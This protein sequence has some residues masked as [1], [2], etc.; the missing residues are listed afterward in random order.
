MAVVLDS[1]AMLAELFKEPGAEFVMAHA[2]EPIASAVNTAEVHAKL[3]EPSGRS[4]AINQDA[5]QIWSIEN[6][7]RF[8]VVDF[9]AEQALRTGELRPLT[10]HLGL[11]LGDRACLALALVRRLPVLTADR[12]WLGLKLGVEIRLIR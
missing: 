8:R 6:R 12:S 3:R 2:D 1:S 9:D 7:W 5:Y 4:G 10:R 11:S